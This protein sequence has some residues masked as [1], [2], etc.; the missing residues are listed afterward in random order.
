MQLSF[1]PRPPPSSKNQ[2]QTVPQESRPVFVCLTFRKFISHPFSSCGSIRPA[3]SSLKWKQSAAFLIVLS[4]LSFTLP[5]PFLGFPKSSPF[6][7]L[8]PTQRTQVE[9]I[10]SQRP[11]G[12][13]KLTWFFKNP[14][15][16][17]YLPGFVP[18][19]LLSECGVLEIPIFRKF[20]PQSHGEHSAADSCTDRQASLCSCRKVSRSPLAGFFRPLSLFANH[21]RSYKLFPASPR[22]TTIF[23]QCRLSLL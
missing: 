13:P 9:R 8:G 16:L 20:F 5:P 2:L 4:P 1:I 7:R 18:H 12:Y 3:A 23:R 22:L 19:L 21:N 10:G 15:F 6:K 14:L 11:K 17:D